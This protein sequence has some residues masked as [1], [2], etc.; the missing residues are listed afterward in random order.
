MPDTEV[1][2]RKRSYIYLIPPFKI[3]EINYGISEDNEGEKQL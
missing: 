2:R 3:N 1:H